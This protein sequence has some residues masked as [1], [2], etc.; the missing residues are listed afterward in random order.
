MDKEIWWITKKEKMDVATG[1]IWTSFEWSQ[2]T[3]HATEYILNE[4]C[5]IFVDDRLVLRDVIN[6]HANVQPQAVFSSAMIV[7]VKICGWGE[8]Q[9]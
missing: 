3:W 2:E 4:Y 7:K 1:R 8:E 5:Q 9:Q 6:F